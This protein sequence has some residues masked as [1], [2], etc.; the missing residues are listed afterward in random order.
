MSPPTTLIFKNNSLFKLLSFK[1]H[2]APTIPATYVTITMI[3]SPNMRTVACV[4]AIFTLDTGV[5]S[6]YAIAPLS[7]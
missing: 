4:I 6:K 7:T 1:S 2:S 3:S 5:A